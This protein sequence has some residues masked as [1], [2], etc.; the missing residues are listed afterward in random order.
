M[1]RNTA[2]FLHRCLP[3]ARA[4][5]ETLQRL[6]TDRILLLSKSRP[7]TTIPLAQN[8]A[9]I[10][11][12]FA[13]RYGPQARQLIAGY[14]YTQVRLWDAGATRDDMVLN[15][16][17]IAQSIGNLSRDPEVTAATIESSLAE[18]ILLLVDARAIEQDNLQQAMA[19]WQR[20]SLIA[21]R[22]A[23]DITAELF[24]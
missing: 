11:E 5:P 13:P 21:E 12:L 20:A 24:W 23:R 10:G 14:F 18:Y 3:G 19:Y 16:R 4:H 1:L 6:L 8:S 15:A 17:A 2:G 22:L 9:E 7:D